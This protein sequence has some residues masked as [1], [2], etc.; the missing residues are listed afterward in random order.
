VSPKLGQG[1]GALL[2]DLLG[3]ATSGFYAG[4]LIVVS[5]LRAQGAGAGTVLFRS[6]VVFSALLLPLALGQKIWPDTARGWW[7]LIGLALVGQALGQ[8]LIAYAFKHLP[9]ALGA[10]G[11]YVQS[12]ATAVYAWVLLGERL[13]LAQIAG[14]VIVLASVAAAKASQ[15]P[16]PAPAAS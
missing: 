13:T 6:S 15:S 1:G 5:R 10:A 2:G 3:V 9:A 12:V 7:V 14:C 16:P 4:Y 11:L 8:G